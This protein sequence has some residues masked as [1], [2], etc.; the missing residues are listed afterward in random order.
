M[1]DGITIVCYICG[2]EM[3]GYVLSFIFVIFLTLGLF[4]AFDKDGNNPF[5]NEK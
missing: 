2:M 1:F 5:I 4:G 3:I